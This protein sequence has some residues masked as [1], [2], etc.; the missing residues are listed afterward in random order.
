MTQAA[1]LAYDP[2]R[3]ADIRLTASISVAHFVS[4]YYLLVLPP[5]FAFVREDYGV[6]YTGLGLALTVLN[7]ASAILQTPAG[8]LVDRVN[9]RL[10]LIAGLVLGAI[11]Y[12]VAAVVD[13]FWVLVAMFGVLGVANTVYHPADYAILSRRI[14][15]D[16]VSQAYSIHTFAGM[17]GSA[18]TPAIALLLHNAFGWR[19]AF[20]GT[21]VLGFAVALWLIFQPDGP[22][23]PAPTRPHESPAADTSWRLLLSAPI[24]ANFLF[25]TVLAFSNFG[26]QNFSVVALGALYGTPPVTAN[27]ALS[28]HLLLSAVGVLLG[29]WIAARITRH[30]LAA[31]IGLFATV[32]AALLIGIVDLGATLL[33]LVMSLSGFC[34]GAIMP[35]RDMIVREV[36]PPG[37]FGKVFGFVTNGFNIAGII[38][39]LMFGALLDQGEPRTVFFV[40]AGF[41]L[42]SIAT[43]ASVPQ[44]RTA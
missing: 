37:A 19:G 27:A 33:I 41:A 12:A 24:L 29:G 35:S 22:S 26:L 42:L 38:A 13:S 18:A 2:R 3:A 4:H 17:L 40:I 36:T 30:R 23:E 44:R 16:F 9:A 34:V 7:V 43:V 21:A 39:P 1:P 32:I 5:L 10:V 20:L 31:S 25:F 6:S 14:G 15:P 28:S 8:F 11:A